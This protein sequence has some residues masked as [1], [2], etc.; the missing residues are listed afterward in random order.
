MSGSED[1]V[2]LLLGDKRFVPTYDTLNTACYYGFYSVVEKLLSMKNFNLSMENDNAIVCAASK[3]NLDI[4]KLLEKDGRCN[5]YDSNFS[6]AF[7]GAAKFDH[8]DVLHHIY[9]KSSVLEITLRKA[10]GSGCETNSVQ[11]LVFCLKKISSITESDLVEWFNKSVKYYCYKSARVLCTHPKFV[12]SPTILE[13][14]ESK[15]WNIN[16]MVS[17][18]Y[19]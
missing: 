11:A 12:V 18:S 5:I 8:M 7:I 14:V 6:E 4:I 15:N 13:A 9:Q 19:F 1:I 10:I 16:E 2:L 17:T 3:G